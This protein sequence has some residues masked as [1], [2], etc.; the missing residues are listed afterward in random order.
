VYPLEQAIDTTERATAL[1]GAVRALPADIQHYK[2]F[3]PLRT[4]VLGWLDVARR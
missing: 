2:S 3:L 4:A 1:A